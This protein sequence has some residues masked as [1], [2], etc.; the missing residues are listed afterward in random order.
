M[1]VLVV[2]SLGAA[3]CSSS[4]TM[5]TASNAPSGT[6]GTTDVTGVQSF[7]GLARNHVATPVSYPQ[8]PP[9]GGDHAR[10]WQNCGVYDTQ[11]KNENA[12]HS[13]EHGAVWLAYRPDLPADQVDQ[14]R[15]LARNHT[16]VLV[17]PYAGITEAVV[18]TAWGKQLRLDSVGDPRLGQFV[19][20]YEEGPQT[21][22][23]GVTC[24][25]GVGSPIE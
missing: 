3:A 18:A 16:H 7:T 10:V 1:A 14:I 23:L 15:T 17:S 6:T 19:A 13:L 20:A 5:S 21:P 25:G 24:S 12:V 2:A 9:V 4:A 11:P 22:E 8:S